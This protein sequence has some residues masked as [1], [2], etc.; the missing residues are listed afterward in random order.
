MLRVG[1]ALLAVPS[2]EAN[3]FGFIVFVLATSLLEPGTR[4]L[5][6]GCGLGAQGLAAAVAGGQVTFVDWDPRALELVAHS[7]EVL[8][9]E[10][11]ALETSD[12]RELGGDAR[13]DR[14]LG[15]DLLYEVRNVPAVLEV[16]SRR[17]A[18]GGE[19]WIADPGRDGLA[20]FVG[21]LPGH[22]LRLVER[23]P[24]APRPHGVTVTLLRIAPM[25]AQPPVR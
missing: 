24:L 15:A 20:S 14:V 13:Y 23:R 21:G 3:L 18:R 25:V 12:W 9:V 6:L 7:A 2:L 4:V 17:I 11:S 16:L 5:D 22:G 1:S 19:A 10:P 8:G